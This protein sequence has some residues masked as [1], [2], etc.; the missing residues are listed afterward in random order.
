MKL[1]PFALTFIASLAFSTTAFGACNAPDD[2]E[3]PSGDSAS[4]AD[5][6]K[7]KKAV[8]AYVSAAQEYMD[9]GVSTALQSRMASKMEKV[10]DAFN[11]E[12][13]AYKAKS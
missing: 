12:L 11:K 3:I 6:L 10:V 2:P 8:E 9:C 13:R 5:M 1:K 7:S 4:G